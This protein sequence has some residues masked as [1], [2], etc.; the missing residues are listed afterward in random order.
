MPVPPSS[1]DRKLSYKYAVSLGTRQLGGGS[2]AHVPT[3]GRVSSKSRG[4]LTPLCVC[5][6]IFHA[7]TSHVVFFRAIDAML[8]FWSSFKIV[9]NISDP[10]D[11]GRGR[12]E[13]FEQIEAN[14]SSTQTLLVEDQELEAK[15]LWHLLLPRSGRRIWPDLEAGHCG[16]RYWAAKRPVKWG[17]DGLSG[18]KGGKEEATA[19][20]SGSSGGLWPSRSENQEVVKMS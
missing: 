16:L 13:A 11:Q 4:T 15:G 14:G 8:E 9:L 1:A 3:V 17:N 10:L 19:P 7:M 18:G 5:V 12:A 6:R 20:V 2:H